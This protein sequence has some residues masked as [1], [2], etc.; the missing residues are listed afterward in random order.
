MKCAH[1]DG[2]VVL[3]SSPI[4]YTFPT[5]YGYLCGALVAAGERPVMLFRDHGIEDLLDEIM[6]A[7]PLLV[8]F[9]SLYVELEEVRE[10]ITALDEVGR[11]F[12]IVVGGNMVSP[13]PEFAVRR[14]G[15]D[16]GTIGEAELTLVEL[17]RALRNGVD[18]SGQPG[19]CVRRDDGRVVSN[20]PGPIITDLR[21]LPAVPY[22]LFPTDQWLNIGDWYAHNY[23]H[24]N[25][26]RAGDRVINLHGARGCP[27]TCNFCMHFNRYRVRPLTDVFARAQDLVRRFDA[28]MLYFSDD[29]ALAS[30]RRAEQVVEGIARLDRPVSYSVSATF[31]SLARIDDHLLRELAR[32]GCRIMG[33]GAESG[34][35]RILRVICPGTVSAEQMR[36]EWRRLRAAGIYGTATMQFGQHTETLEDVEQTIAFVKGAV[37]DAPEAQ[38]NFT[39]T[40]PFPG[41]PLYQT[42][43][44]DGRV[45]D[46]DDF[47][48]RYHH[49]TEGARV[50]WCRQVVN[51][52]QMTDVE[53]LESYHRARRVYLETKAHALGCST[54]EVC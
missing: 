15:A 34:S 38:W 3:V 18:P 8:G 16:Y 27:N 28:N 45:R 26:W 9:G 30:P 5:A 36:H 39:I 54:T 19:L 6:N 23:P 32:T 33:L 24:Q 49:G 35:D 42:L 47:H 48:E 46:I 7:R 43:L 41:S 37:E 21:N 13:T 4:A 52:S 1:R 44:R 51:F 20:G 11:D 29:T 14:T 40:T 25:L 50:G 22:E 53:V 31:D 10:I 12:P 17:V 2:P